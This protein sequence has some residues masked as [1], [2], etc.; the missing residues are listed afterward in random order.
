MP[1]V[2]FGRT[3]PPQAE[4]YTTPWVQGKAGRVEVRS[5]PRHHNSKP[6]TQDDSARAQQRHNELKAFLDYERRLSNAYARSQDPHPRRWLRQ[7]SGR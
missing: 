6:M 7:D 3:H 1:G 2:R 4:S 5:I